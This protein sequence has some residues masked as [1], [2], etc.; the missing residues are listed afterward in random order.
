M[1]ELPF[2]VHYPGVAHTTEGAEMAALKY[3]SLAC[4]VA[5]LIVLLTVDAPT[6]AV[7]IMSVF[8]ALGVAAAIANNVPRRVPAGQ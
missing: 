3:M 2:D 5:L 6:W 4:P 1:V 7:V 8:I